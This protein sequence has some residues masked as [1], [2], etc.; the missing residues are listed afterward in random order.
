MN[1]SKER[2]VYLYDRTLQVATNDGEISE[3]EIG[4]LIILSQSLEKN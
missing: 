2:A 3:D 1:L 4:I